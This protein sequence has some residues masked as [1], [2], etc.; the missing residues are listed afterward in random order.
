[1]VACAFNPWIWETEV[2]GTLCISDPPGLHI[3]FKDR[4]D[5]TERQCLKTETFL[6]VCVHVCC[7]V[8]VHYMYAGIHRAQRVLDPQQLEFQAIVRHMTWELRTDSTK[9]V[10]NL[11]QSNQHW[12]P[13]P[14]LCQL[15]SL[16]T[17]S[18]CNFLVWFTFWVQSL[19]FFI[20]VISSHQITCHIQIK[21]V[22][23]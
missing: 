3:E 11:N 21:I 7:W 2:G 13:P 12:H 22:L 6:N 5:Y 19:H 14:F 16:L 17:S 10:S 8:Y 4:Q 1:M 18:T 15:S 20:I 23:K 9:A